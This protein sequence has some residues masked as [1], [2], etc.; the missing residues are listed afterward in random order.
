MAAL[1]TFQTLQTFRSFRI[2]PET[3]EISF[4]ARALAQDLLSRSI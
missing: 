2:R 4:F 1:L 3:S